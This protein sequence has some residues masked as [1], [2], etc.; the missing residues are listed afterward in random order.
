MS[1]IVLNAETDLGELGERLDRYSY[2]GFDDTLVMFL[3]GGPASS[4]V[5]KLIKV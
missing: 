3:P 2:V 5:R 4:N 1:T